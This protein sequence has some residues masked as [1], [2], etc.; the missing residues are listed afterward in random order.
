MKKE[1][2]IAYLSFCVERSTPHPPTLKRG[3]PLPQRG[4][5]RAG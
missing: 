3:R 5:V 4:E 2:V 1:I